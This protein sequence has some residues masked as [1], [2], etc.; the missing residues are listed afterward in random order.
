MWSEVPSRGSSKQ[1]ELRDEL[2]HLNTEVIYEVVK[3][4]L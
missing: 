3:T 1:P 4:R 2:T